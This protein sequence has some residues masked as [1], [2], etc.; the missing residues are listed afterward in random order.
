LLHELGTTS[1]IIYITELQKQLPH[2][3]HSF[4]HS[5]ISERQNLIFLF[6]EEHWIEAC[7]IFTD[8]VIRCSCI[9]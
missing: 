8:P 4:I 2:S 1:L 7:E 5:F 6:L 9:L 3:C